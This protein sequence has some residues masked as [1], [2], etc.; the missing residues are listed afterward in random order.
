VDNFYYG[1]GGTYGTYK[2]KEGMDSLIEDGE[3][4]KFYTINLRSGINYTHSRPKVDWR[5]IGIELSYNNEFGPYQD[6]LSFL[7]VNNFQGIIA[8]QKSML[9]YQIYS[10]Y[11]FKTIS[12]DAFTLGFYVG[13]ILNYKNT[14]MYSGSTVFSG[15]SLG[16]RVKKYAFYTL[17]ETGEGNIKSTKFGLSYRL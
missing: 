3:K 15:F 2:F 17:F 1:I 5:F 14:E 12:Q 13:D 10:E 11:V 6:K 16:L 7:E 8:N 9:N 4:K